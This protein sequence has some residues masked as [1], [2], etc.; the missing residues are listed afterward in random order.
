MIHLVPVSEVDRAWMPIAEGMKEACRR[1]GDDLT[2]AD[3]FRQCRTG[4]ALFFVAFVA[5][6]IKAGL[7]CRPEMWG[8]KQVLRIL[9]LTGWDMDQWLPALTE[10]REW[11]L[12]LDVKAVVFEGREGWKRVLKNVR[13]IRTVYEVELADGG[14]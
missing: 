2:V 3:L 12:A 14:R 8:G 9:A 13:V 4:H 5:D 7:V 11:P 1:G 10:Y 6:E